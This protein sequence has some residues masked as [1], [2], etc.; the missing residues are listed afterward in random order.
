[1][2]LDDHW[3]IIEKVKELTKEEL[4]DRVIEATGKEWPLNLSGELLK[5]RGKLII[6]GFHQ[7]GMR[8][9]NVQLWNWKGLDVINAHERDP[10]VYMDGIAEAIEAVKTGK[11]DLEPLLTHSFSLD[12]ADQAFEHLK[13]RPDGFLKAVLNF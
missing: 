9:I 2:P 4:C 11:I 3:K 5:N 10:Q 7:D 13:N 8:A 12:D 1:M 6:A